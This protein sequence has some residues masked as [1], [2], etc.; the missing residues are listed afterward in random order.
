MIKLYYNPQSRA[1]MTRCLLEELRVPYE[2]EI[3]NYEDGSMRSPEFLKIN[4]MGKVPAIRDGETVVTESAAII[5]YLA[6]KYKTHNDLAPDIDHKDR[7]EYL[8][9][10]VFCSSC[11]DPAMA[12]VGLKFEGKRQSLGWGT[13]ELVFS[14]VE[15][16]LEKAAP[17]LF[18]SQLTAADIFLGMSMGWAMQFGL[19]PKAPATSRYV[20]HIQNLDGWKAVQ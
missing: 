12:Q 7:G 20:E 4:P 13:P 10:I 3:L 2:I 15:S 19:A 8:R 17:Y 1:V 16:R 18:G 14:T 6:D 9:W 11:I 5:L